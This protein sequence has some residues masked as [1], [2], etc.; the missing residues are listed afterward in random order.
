MNQEMRAEWDL[1]V[2][3]AAKAE[4][5]RD[6]A[7]ED[8]KHCKSVIHTAEKDRAA[9]EA[10]AAAMRE[11][12]SE[13]LGSL[14]VINCAASTIRRRIDDPNLRPTEIAAEIERERLKAH[15]RI[16]AAL[17]SDAGAPYLRVLRKMVSAVLLLDHPNRIEGC[18]HCE[19]VEALRAADMPLL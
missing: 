12:L 18:P 19:A 8:A 10:K 17:Q 4:Q 15:K 11:A 9:L 13:T 1:L 5:E 3:R 16:S 6:G 14:H 2:D 7:Q